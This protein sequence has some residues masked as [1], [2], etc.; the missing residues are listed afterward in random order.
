MAVGINMEITICRTFQEDLKKMAFLFLIIVMSFFADYKDTESIY[1]AVFVQCIGN[2]E[3]FSDILRN[4]LLH[5]TTRRLI[6]FILVSSFCAAVFIIL[7]WCNNIACMNKEWVKCI[8]IGIC[9]FPF[10]FWLRDF[11]LNSKGR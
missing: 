4:P 5:I 11:C 7:N 9:I 1:I 3:D 8:F 2:V 6:V 10:V